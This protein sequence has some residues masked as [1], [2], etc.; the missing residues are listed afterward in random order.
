M[1]EGALILF[2]AIGWVSTYAFDWPTF[3]GYIFAGLL[4]VTV[5]NIIPKLEKYNRL[6]NK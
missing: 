6:K 2:F 3:I 1:F 4:G 5:G